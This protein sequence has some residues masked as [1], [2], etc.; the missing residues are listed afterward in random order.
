MQGLNNSNQLYFLPM[1]VL[2]HHKKKKY[3]TKHSKLAHILSS[4]QLSSVARQ[5]NPALITKLTSMFLNIAIKVIFL[6]VALR[7]IT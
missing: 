2:I 4:P 3:T 6:L 5:T 7:L 1:F